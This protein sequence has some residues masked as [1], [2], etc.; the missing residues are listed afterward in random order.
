MK[1]LK[2]HE[3][4]ALPN[5]FHCPICGKQIVISDIS[6]WEEQDDKTWAVSECGFS[7]GCEI[8]PEI[9]SLER[10]D[11]FSSHWSQPYIDWIGIEDRVYHWLLDNY[12]FEMNPRYSM[13]KG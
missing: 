6:E 10:D 8:E 11:Y 1:T 13:L 7:V 3:I 9:D 5:S 12:R 2:Q 4:P